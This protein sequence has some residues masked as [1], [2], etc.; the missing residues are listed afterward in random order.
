MH[1]LQTPSIWFLCGSQHLYGPGPLRTVAQNAGVVAKAL[2]ASAQVPL[3]VVFK[4]LLTTPEEIRATLLAANGDADCAGVILW[5]H[6]FSPSRMWIGG[7]AA[8]QKPILHLHTQFNREVPW[9]RIDMDFMNLNQAAHGD[10]EAGFMHT[11]LRLRRKVVVGHWSDPEV[12]A[13]VGAWARVTRA[14][15]DLQGAKVARFGDNMRQVAVTE[16]DKVSAE[17]AFGFAVNGYGVGDLAAAVRDVG[18]KAIDALVAEYESEYTLAAPLKKSGAKRA[19][20]REGARI[21]LGL[22]S[23]PGRRRLQ[24]VHDDLRGSARPRAAARARRAAADGRRLRVRRRRRLE[25]VGAAAGDEGDGRR[26]R[27]RHVVHG[28]LHL[29]SCSRRS[30]RCSA[31]TCW[32]SARRSPPARRRSRCTPL[33]IGGKADPVRLVFDAPAGPR[34]QRVAGRSR[35]PLPPDRQRS[36]PR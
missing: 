30:T 19:S 22:R 31:R 1:L 6:T 34:H 33:G 2:D 24:G 7:L 15:H 3:P 12:Q 16:G 29:P 8:L 28:G 14:W 17:I 4:G 26:P 11:R 5:M 35:Q 13:R 21:E 36:G 32:R 18:D 23:V 9:D 20:L 25:D 10:R 27:R